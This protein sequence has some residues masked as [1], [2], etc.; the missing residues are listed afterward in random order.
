MAKNMTDEDRV[1]AHRIKY[2]RELCG[3]TQHNFA[4]FM[5]VT[6]QMVQKYENGQSRL[7]AVRLNRLAQQLQLPLEWFFAEPNL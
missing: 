2:L 7:S 5:G 3:Y 1:L 6:F 4:Q